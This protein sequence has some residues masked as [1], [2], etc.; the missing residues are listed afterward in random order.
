MYNVDIEDQEFDGAPA[1]PGTED[2]DL[3]TVSIRIDQDTHERLTT[4]KA[5][6]PGP[7]RKTISRMIDISLEAWMA[8]EGLTYEELA[9]RKLR[10]LSR[11]RV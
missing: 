4:C 6:L 11:R 7:G 9:N 3:T 1:P 2:D 10:I 8:C 5:A